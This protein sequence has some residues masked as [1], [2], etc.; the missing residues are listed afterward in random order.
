M[1]P[2]VISDR[3]GA[4]PVCGMD[5]VLKSGAMT[6]QTIDKSL[7][8]VLRSANETVISSITTTRATFKSVPV[9][10][11][12]HGVVTYDTRNLFT[13]SSRVSGRIEN[14]YIKFPYQAIRKGERVAEI[15]SPELVAA[16]RDLL[17]L[18]QNDPENDPLITA[19]KTRLEILGMSQRQVSDLMKSGKINNT[20]TLYSP[21]TGYA[22]DPGNVIPPPDVSSNVNTNQ[23]GMTGGM[24]AATNKQEPTPMSTSF[25][26][27]GN[28]VTAGQPIFKIVN[29]ESLRVELDLPANVSSTVKKGDV[30][31]IDFG[32]GHEQTSTVDFVQPYFERDKQFVKVRVIT[33]HHNDLHIGHLLEARIKSDSIEGMWIPRESVIDLGKEKVVFLKGKDSF[34]PVRIIT[35]ISSNGEVQILEGITSGDEIAANAQFLI[36]S[37]SIIKIDK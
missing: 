6:E 25:L 29:N 3:P 20:I 5:L 33:A 12:A 37:E 19:S 7:T 26:K 32:V 23:G 2:T 13:I 30:I 18:L 14:L 9:T 28:Y 27:E 21:Y 22:V 35:G 34:K 4:C 36:D 15:Y 17:F 31:R 10:Y 8:P 1:H 11:E 16:Q 24:S